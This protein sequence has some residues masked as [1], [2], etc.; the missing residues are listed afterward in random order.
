MYASSELA[1]V[2]GTFDFF[3]LLT[4]LTDKTRNSVDGKILTA[5]KPTSFL[6][7]LARRKVLKAATE[8]LRDF[9]MSRE[10]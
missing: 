6:V 4:P 1:D 10:D 5:M 3:V 2:V 7:N 8:G 9:V